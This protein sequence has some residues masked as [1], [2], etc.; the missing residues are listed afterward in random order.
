MQ[1]H[2]THA[3]LLLRAELKPWLTWHRRRGPNTPVRRPFVLAILFIGAECCRGEIHWGTRGGGTEW[4][5]LRGG[6]INGLCRLA[7]C[8]R[9]KDR[10]GRKGWREADAAL[11]LEVDRFCGAGRKTRMRCT[12]LRRSLRRV[13]TCGNER[14]NVCTHAA[15]PTPS[16]Q[17][18]SIRSARASLHA[19][20]KASSSRLPVS[21]VGRS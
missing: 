21:G 2:E 6:G 12:R 18:L 3:L 17:I 19:A 20:A 16:R 7:R 15:D 11:T 4:E 5:W 9:E 13:S 8:P 14:A 1:R 10:A